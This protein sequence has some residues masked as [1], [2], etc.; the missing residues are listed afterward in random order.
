MVKFRSGGLGN[1][2]RYAS[3]SGGD[4]LLTATR[5]S[6]PS[7]NRVTALNAASHNRA[8][9]ATM[10]S[11]TGWASAGELEITRRISLVAVCCSSASVGVASRRALL[12]LS[13]RRD[14]RKASTWAT[15]SPSVVKE[16]LSPRRPGK[17]RHQLHR[18]GLF[19]GDRQSGD[20]ALGP[21]A[22]ALADARDRAH[23]RHLVAELVGHGRH[24]VLLPPGQEQL[25]DPLRRVAKAAADHHLLVEVLVTVAHAADV[26]RH[27]RFH[28]RERAA[29]IV[30]DRD[31]GARLDLEIAEALAPARAAKAF[32]EPGPQHRHEPRNEAERQPP[33]GDLRRQLH[34][35]LGAGAEPD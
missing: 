26:E 34:V 24:G 4:M 10:A 19:G 18:F 32:L 33:I 30:G 21:G 5:W 9:L 25:L 1:R 35:R 8:A 13:S 23:Q 27:V 15:R 2:L 12:A 3:V 17:A 14:F 22:V 31:L 11:N 7:S 28:A 20:A 29:H 6:N 16:S